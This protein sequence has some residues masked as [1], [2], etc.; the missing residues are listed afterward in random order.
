MIVAP[1]LYVMPLSGWGQGVYDTRI[2]S[3]SSIL[4]TFHFVNKTVPMPL[5]RP[6]R[7]MRGIP[8]TP[9]PCHSAH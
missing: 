8:T 6:A 2:F 5:Q 4:P 7:F 3:L 9:N 1:N